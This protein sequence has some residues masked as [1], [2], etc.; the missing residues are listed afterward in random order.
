MG[1]ACI[2]APEQKIRIKDL[3]LWKYWISTHNTFFILGN[4]SNKLLGWNHSDP[5]PVVAATCCFSASGKYSKLIIIR[6]IQKNHRNAPLLLGLG[7]EAGSRK[8]KGKFKQMKKPPNG[9]E[10]TCSEASQ[11]IANFHPL[12]PNSIHLQSSV[13]VIIIVTIIMI[14]IVLM[15]F[16]TLWLFWKVGPLLAT[17][18]A[19]QEGQRCEA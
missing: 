2:F 19:P 13:P 8:K 5:M 16:S 3:K 11:S 14:M 6:N 12:S 1:L 10:I 18:L 17:A 4:A 15:W 9:P 7:Q